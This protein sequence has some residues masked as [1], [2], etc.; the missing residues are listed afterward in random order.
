MLTSWTVSI[1]ISTNVPQDH[2]LFRLELAFTLSTGAGLWVLG[3]AGEG[4][5]VPDDF[6]WHTKTKTIFTSKTCVKQFKKEIYSY[7][8]TPF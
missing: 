2:L 5:G 8:D 3:R 6:A 4:V 1:D 7:I